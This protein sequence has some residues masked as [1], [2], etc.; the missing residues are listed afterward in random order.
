M[1]QFVKGIPVAK[2]KK[3]NKSK[4]KSA[5]LEQIVVTYHLSELP[6]AFHKA[7]LAGLIMLIESMKARHELTV[8][9]AEYTLT[10]TTVVV[11]FTEAMLQK[12]MN[13]RMTLVL[14]K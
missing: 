1:F 8:S 4:A 12:V 5:E 2:S 10:P 3:P 13:D 6:T 7:G 14:S 11:T 9:D